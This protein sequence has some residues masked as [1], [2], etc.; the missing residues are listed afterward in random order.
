MKARKTVQ[1][2]NEKMGDVAA[3]YRAGVHQAPARTVSTQGS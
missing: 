2:L 3:S 1:G